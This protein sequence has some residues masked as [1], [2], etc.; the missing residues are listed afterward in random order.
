MLRSDKLIVNILYEDRCAVLY[1]QWTTYYGCGFVNDML[2]K[3]FKI[4][5]VPFKGTVT[6]WL[7][8]M[9]N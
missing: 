1:D 3:G 7:A 6:V 9:F 4:K 8:G 2:Y 5:A